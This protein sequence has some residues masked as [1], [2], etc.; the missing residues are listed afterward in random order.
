MLLDELTEMVTLLEVMRN[1]KQNYELR[2]SDL[3]RHFHRGPSGCAAS[4]LELVRVIGPGVYVAADVQYCFVDDSFDTI[5][6]N[7][8]LLEHA[9][10]MFGFQYLVGVMANMFVIQMAGNPNALMDHK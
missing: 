4:L 2:R 7:V 9:I 3:R 10:E 1:R 6:K 8:E 5:V